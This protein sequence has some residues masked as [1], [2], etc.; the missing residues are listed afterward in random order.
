MDR[1]MNDP[2]LDYPYDLR[3]DGRYVYR[4]T[5]ITFITLTFIFGALMFKFHLKIILVLIIVLI[6]ISVL[7]D[8]KFEKRSN[9]RE[10]LETKEKEAK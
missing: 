5:T 3:K 9:L 1:L 2:F 7:I 4:F 10:L 8:N 6:F